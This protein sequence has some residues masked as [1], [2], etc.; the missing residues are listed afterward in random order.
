MSPLSTATPTPLQLI[1]ATFPK[2]GGALPEMGETCRGRTIP[3][4]ARRSHWTRA[5]PPDRLGNESTKVAR[6]V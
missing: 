4:A 5:P 6:P 2:G 1:S 3:A